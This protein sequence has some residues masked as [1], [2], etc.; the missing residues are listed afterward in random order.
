[1]TDVVPESVRV[2]RLARERRR[3]TGETYLQ[4]LAG[5]RAGTPEVVRQHHSRVQVGAGVGAACPWE[6]E[7]RP[8]SLYRF[9]PYLHG[10]MLDALVDRLADYAVTVPRAEVARWTG[11]R[12]L[13][14]WD[15]VLTRSRLDPHGLP[16][17]P[18]VY[19]RKYLV[20]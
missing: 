1:M 19:L 13:Q 16:L 20:Q 17:A 14:V 7:A 8:A 5:V 12:R 9:P 6:R 2:R 18:P 3:R 4:A 11:A 10:A 15:W